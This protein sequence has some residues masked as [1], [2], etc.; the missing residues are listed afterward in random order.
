MQWSRLILKVK[1]RVVILLRGCTI[2]INLFNI[3]FY[4]HVQNNTIFNCT[5]LQGRI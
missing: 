3:Y 1:T 2:Y 5:K 4:K